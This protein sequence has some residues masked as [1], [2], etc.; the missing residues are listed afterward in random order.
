MCGVATN[1]ARESAQ[2][3]QM[4]YRDRQ[5]AAHAERPLG[6]S[7]T[8]VVRLASL[9][10]GHGARQLH[11]ALERTTIVLTLKKILCPIDFSDLNLSALTFAVDLASTFQSELHLL[12]VFEGYDAISL[13]PELAMSPM[14]E[15]LPKLRE[16]CR[17]KLAA[18]PSDDL[19]ARCPSIVRAH[20]EGPAIHEILEYA[21]HEKI[22]LIVLAT[23]GRTG[24]KHL[25]MGSV[26]ENVVRSAKCPVLT[27]R[28]PVTP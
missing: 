14:P 27:I 4:S 25:L 16:L 8:V 26:A 13:N 6:R 22:D 24:L 1:D 11:P 10:Q 21:A 17:E 3:R 23:H 28:S 2:V 12:H 9:L 5:G 18:M 15:W 20:R 19:A 7:L